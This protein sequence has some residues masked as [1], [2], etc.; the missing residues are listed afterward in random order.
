[1]GAQE[2]LTNI[3]ILLVIATI[4]SD[5]KRRD[6]LPAGASGRLTAAALFAGISLVLHFLGR[7]SG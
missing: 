5:M 4:W 2:I 3:S 1:M 7:V 6:N